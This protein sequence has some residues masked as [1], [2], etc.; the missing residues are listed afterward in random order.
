MFFLIK[1]TAI[2]VATGNGFFVQSAQKELQYCMVQENIFYV[3]IVTILPIR[4]SNKAKNI[5]Y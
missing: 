4:A 3:V 5:G 1:H 2:M